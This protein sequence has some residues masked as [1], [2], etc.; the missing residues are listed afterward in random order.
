MTRIIGG[1]A[2]GRVLRT[3]PGDATR[4]TASRVRE[5]LFSSL[6]SSL[7]SLQ[8]VTFLDLYAGSG[9]VGLEAASRGAARVTSVERNRPVAA[10]IAANARTL[11]LE[12]VDVVTASVSALALASRGTGPAYQVVFL[13]PP[14]DEPNDAVAD[15]LARLGPA[16]WVAEGAIVVVERSRRSPAWSWPEGFDAVRDRRYGDTILWYGRRESPHHAVAG[17]AVSDEES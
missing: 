12:Q 6:E 8:G 10:L 7:G 17:E 5:A 4:P 15:A 11:R 3:P 16:G 9:A 13:D 2:R 1:V 14:Y